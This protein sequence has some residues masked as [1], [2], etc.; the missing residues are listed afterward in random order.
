MLFSPGINTPVHPYSPPSPTPPF[1]VDLRQ[2]RLVAELLLEKETITNSD[3]S[4]LIG[5]RP[6]GSNK[7]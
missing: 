3:V 7:E 1:H 6:H 4:G 5:K 2:V